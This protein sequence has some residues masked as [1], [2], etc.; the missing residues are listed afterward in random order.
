MTSNAVMT[1][2]QLRFDGY[3]SILSMLELTHPKN[4][5]YI[6]TIKEKIAQKSIN[7]GQIKDE[8]TRLSHCLL[9]E[10][11]EEAR[12]FRMASLEIGAAIKKI[13]SSPH[14]SV[15]QRSMIDDVEL[16]K[17]ATAADSLT[18][19]GRLCLAFATESINL[20]SSSELVVG[21]DHKHIQQNSGNVIAG[22]ISWSS[23]QIVNSILPLL[24]RV[25]IEYPDRKKITKLLHD[26]EILKKQHNIDFF[27]ALKLMESSTREIAILQGKRDNADTEYLKTFHFHLKE[28]HQSLQ[29]T[30]KNNA[31]FNDGAD[32]DKSDFN[33]IISQFKDASE[34]EEDPNNL[35]L[36]I[37]KNIENLS[38]S[39]SKIMSKQDAHIRN[40]QRELGQLS[41]EIRTQ[42]KFHKEAIE[43]RDKMIELVQEI[44][45]ASLIDHLTQIPNR[46]AYE[47]E[48]D[49]LDTHI[50]KVKTQD[51]ARFGVA[52]VDVDHFKKINDNFGHAFGD[53]VLKFT[54]NL[55][56][57]V[58]DKARLSK[59]V[60][61]YRYGGEEFVLIFRGL[62]INDMAKLLELIRNRIG[63]V[64]LKSEGKKSTTITV[65]SGLASYSALDKKG[66]SVF[67]VADKAMYYAKENGRDRVIIN[68]QQRHKKIQ[69]NSDNKIEIVD[70]NS[71]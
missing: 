31:L 14:L 39:F 58:I 32:K 55:I 3:V 68:M 4:K 71:Y 70:T 17:G 27:D 5:K 22:D 62:N 44:S 51:L 18:S 20:R 8:M 24:K 54:A 57:K 49:E 29:E 19:I 13:T 63:N 52:V 64:T 43:S 56:Q 65:S 61:V 47:K 23:K 37:S 66:K 28:M 67:T 38:D 25:S 53:N 12:S 69:R 9:Q 11:D 48:L 26:A 34:N 50:Q 41:S 59:R 30:I 21:E 16:D 45:T 2:S 42:E 15:K 33:N 40:Q 10:R 36:L 60:R 35:K 6:A 1:N 46:R 7:D